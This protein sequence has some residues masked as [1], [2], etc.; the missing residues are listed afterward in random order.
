MK[1]I[2]I[3]SL[4][5]CIFLDFSG[6]PHFACSLVVCP[7]LQVGLAGLDGWEE[8]YGAAMTV[9]AFL[10]N[11]KLACVGGTV[12]Q[13]LPWDDWVAVLLSVCHPANAECCGFNLNILWTCTN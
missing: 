7:H 10:E 2:T 1:Q 4:S 3:K 13:R 12:S 6:L 5:F 8:V 11:G 9:L